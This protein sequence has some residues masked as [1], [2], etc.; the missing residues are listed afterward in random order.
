MTKP[1]PRPDALR[2]ALRALRRDRGE[3]ERLARA[4]LAHSDRSMHARAA[5]VQ[6][7]QITRATITL[8]L[9]REACMEHAS[10]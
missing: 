4:W 1:L 3:Y 7:R 5:Y 8:E 6:W 9:E 2:W 10:R